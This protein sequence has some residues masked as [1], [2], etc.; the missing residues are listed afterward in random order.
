[1][2]EKEWWKSTLAV[3]IHD[4][5]R[6]KEKRIPVFTASSPQLN[7]RRFLVDWLAIISEKLKSSHGVLHLAVSYM[8]Y[9][10]DKFDIQEPQL[11]L[12]ALSCFL[13][14]GSCGKASLFASKPLVC[15]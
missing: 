4:G 14:A 5:H 7:L 8:D 10:M 1:M 6:E 12:V 15:Y 3:E 11:H 13:L 9:F 2:P